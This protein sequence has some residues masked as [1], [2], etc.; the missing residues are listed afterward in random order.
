MGYAKKR[1]KAIKK[2]RIAYLIVSAVVVLAIAVLVTLSFVFSAPE[3]KYRVALPKV[4]SRGENEL[5]IHYLDVGQGDATLI[6]LPD[7]KVMLID[8]GNGEEETNCT[9]LRYL[10]ALKIQTIDYLVA[11]HADKDHCGGLAEVVRYKE[12]KCAYLPTLQ[13]NVD[14]NAYAAY[15]ALTYELAKKSCESKLS[16][17]PIDLSVTDG[18]TPYVLTFLYPYHYEVAVSGEANLSENNVSAVIWLDY[19]GTSAIFAGDISSTVEDKLIEDAELGLLEGVELH[20]TELVKVAHHGSNS[21]TSDAW[22]SYLHAKDAIV[23]CG[24]G[25]LYGHPAQELLTRLSAHGVTTYRTDANGTIVATIAAD[26]KYTVRS[27]GK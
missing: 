15:A 5:R 11:T 1:E 6:E 24:V 7:G 26:G 10:N 3:W 13:A 8:G 12:V 16:D 23:S 27:R 4:S 25:N 9:V 17:R 21:S 18:A 22:L 14:D 2:K 20:A 19:H